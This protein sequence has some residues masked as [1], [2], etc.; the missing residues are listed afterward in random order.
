[1]PQ[2]LHSKVS[3]AT[4]V[5]A[6]MLGIAGLS[7][8]ASAAT[9]PAPAARPAVVKTSGTV[10]AAALAKRTAPATWVIARAEKAFT[11][12]RSITNAPADTIDCFS[13][14]SI[15][16]NEN[17]H[18]VSEEQGYS[19]ANAHM[20]R[21]RATVVGPWELYT[22]C[23]DENSFATDM[24]SQED[25]LFVSEEQGYTG[26]NQYE[27]R[28]RAASVGPWETWYTAVDPCNGCNVV[29]VSGE[30]DNYVS[31]E[32]GY[33]GSSQFELRARAAVAGPWES[34]NW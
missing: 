7:P 29:F 24:L 20:L 3:A 25:S 19:G 21:A 2:I 26:A 32:Q 13:N 5:A 18:F 33:T 23:R 30:N 34:F 4:A 28:A 9:K 10:L 27:L 12:L 22:V 8:V 6:A 17:G 1:M 15:Q 16:S 11:V 14:V 31:E